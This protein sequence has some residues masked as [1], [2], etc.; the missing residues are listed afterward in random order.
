MEWIE[1]DFKRH[2]LTHSK[3]K[4]KNIFTETSYRL[5]RSTKTYKSFV[6]IVSC[7]VA[8]TFFKFM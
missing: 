4:S 3:N 5:I 1:T 2:L 6:I 7:N 8:Y